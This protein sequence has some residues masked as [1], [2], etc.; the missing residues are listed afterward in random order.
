MIRRLL[1]VLVLAAILVPA[2]AV[3]PREQPTEAQPGTC[4]FTLGFATLRGMII[5]QFGDIVGP[6]LE[7]EWHNAFNGDGLQQTTGGLMVW[8]KCDN[9]TAFT[10][11]STTWLNGP[12]GL[13]TRPNA[14]PLFPFEASNCP[15]G[16]AGPP[17]GPSAP[18]PPAPAQPPAPTATAIPG[19]PKPVVTI[20]LPE[21]RPR[22]NE[23]FSIRL[24]AS[25]DNGIESMWW[26]AT[27]TSDQ[28]LRETHT[29]DCEAAT[30]CRASWNAS[31]EDRGTIIIHALARDTNGQLSDEV[32]RE[33]RVRDEAATATPT[34]G[35]T[36]TPTPTRTSTPTP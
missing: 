25:D 28:N 27:D 17:P 33:L 32:T 13:V 1:T 35:S 5:A 10:N 16:P 9:W 14:G 21:D 36:S 6:C 8:R 7:N 18:P 30:P 12:T 15:A 22:A 34:T 20:S 24:E 11:G 19:N 31:T 2:A 4:T 3:G 23:E 29:R 26:W